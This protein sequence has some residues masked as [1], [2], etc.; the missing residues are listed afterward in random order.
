MPDVDMPDLQDVSDRTGKGLQGSSDSLM[1]LLNVAGA[2][3]GAMASRR[4]SQGRWRIRRILRRRPIGRIV[5]W[6]IARIRIAVRP[7]ARLTSTCSASLSESARPGSSRPRSADFSSDP[8]DGRCRHVATVNPEY[9]MAARSDPAFAAALRAA[10]LNT[11]DGV[12]VLL[13]AWLQSLE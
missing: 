7:T 1:G 5:G 11:V 3:F 8:W 10:D 12:G 13:A 6:R 2:V 9:V 4:R